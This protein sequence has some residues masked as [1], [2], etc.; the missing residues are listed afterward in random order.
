MAEI[1]DTTKKVTEMQHVKTAFINLS[2]LYIAAALF[3]LML[4]LPTKA[5]WNLI[6]ILWNLI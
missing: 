2:K 1:T 3:I 6:L 4:T 5:I